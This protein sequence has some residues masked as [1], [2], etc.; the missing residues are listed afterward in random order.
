VGPSGALGAHVG[1]NSAVMLYC[2]LVILPLESSDR[3]SDDAASL[4]EFGAASPTKD[5]IS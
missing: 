3:M 1:R 4:T 5:A 2:A